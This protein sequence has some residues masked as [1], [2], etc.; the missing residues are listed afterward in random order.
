MTTADLFLKVAVVK[1][2][3]EIRSLSGEVIVRAVGTHP[4]Q[5]IKRMRRFIDAVEEEQKAKP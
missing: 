5:A 3:V 1:N 4:L 2:T